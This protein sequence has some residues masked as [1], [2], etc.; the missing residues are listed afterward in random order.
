MEATANELAVN[1]DE[2]QLLIANA[3]ATNPNL[4]PCEAC[5]S[6]LTAASSLMAIDDSGMAAMAQIFGTLAPSDAPFTPE[7]S[8][9]VATAFAD[10]REM[11]TQLATMTDE[12]YQEY[13]QYAMADAIVE[14]FVSYVAV[15][16]NDLKL[17]IGDSMALVMEK[18]FEQIEISDNPN[19]GA[20]LI[21]EM[22]A[23]RSISN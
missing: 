18:Y 1:S 13:Q 4:Q 7:V 9:S 22:E 16:E 21:A 17:P 6:L 11:D 14:A 20:Y 10:F 19:I 2:L 3:M 15:L 5:Q 23:A 12:D 8:A